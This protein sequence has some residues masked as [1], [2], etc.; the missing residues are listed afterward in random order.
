[1]S[2]RAPEI[3]MLMAAY[4]PDTVVGDLARDLAVTRG[5]AMALLTYFDGVE[6]RAAVENTLNELVD[7]A[8]ARMT[9]LQIADHT[10]VSSQVIH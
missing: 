5:L 4:G 8:R 3:A 6:D 9:L 7:K 1:M 10:A 2:L